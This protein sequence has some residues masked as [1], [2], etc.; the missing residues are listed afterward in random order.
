MTAKRLS[1]VVLAAAS[2]VVLGTGPAAA[3]ADSAPRIMFRPDAIGLFNRTSITVRGLA[4]RSMEVHLRGATDAA[5]L[6]YE[7][8]PY[9]WRQLRLSHGAWRDV[10]PAPALPGIYQLQLRLDGRR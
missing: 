10:L 6:A 5:G 7:W 8:T 3:A 1:L 2:V 9:R 4:A